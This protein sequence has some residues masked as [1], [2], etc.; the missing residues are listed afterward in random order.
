MVRASFGSDDVEQ[1]DRISARS[2]V[3]LLIHQPSPS[4]AA[5]H[6]TTA[7]VVAEEAK[8]ELSCFVLH[9]YK[10]SSLHKT[11]A[12]KDLATRL[13]HP[14]IVL[15]MEAHTAFQRLRQ[16]V[17]SAGEITRG[18]KECQLQPAPVVCANLNQEN[19]RSS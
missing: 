5:V 16:A 19:D 15:E 17:K 10:T 7:R 4:F 1:P 6:D 18:G 12:D 9:Q 2:V 8:G 3:Q 11:K 14:S 13:A